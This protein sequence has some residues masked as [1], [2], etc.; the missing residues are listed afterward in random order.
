MNYFKKIIY[1]YRAILFFALFV[2]NAQFSWSQ[3]SN[4]E[5]RC[6]WVVRESMVT[7]QDIDSLMIHAYESGYDIIFAQ[8]RGRGDAY[9]ESELVNK[10]KNIDE[11]F[12]PLDYAIKVG[13]SLGLE[14]HAWVNTY[15][16]WSSKWKPYDKDHLYHTKQEWTEADINGKMD[17]RINLSVPQSP[18]WEGIYLSPLHPEVNSYLSSIFDEIIT[19]Y[20]IDGLHLDYI[21]FQDE[22]Y[23]YNPY[24]REKFKEQYNI[25][26][27]DIAR[28]IISTRFGWEQSFVDS[29]QYSWNKFRQDAVTELVES[30]RININAKDKKIKLSAAVKPNLLEAKSRWYQDW[31]VWLKQDL[32]DFAVPMNYF[33]DIRDFNNS[34]LIMKDNL[35]EKDLD[36]IIM[37]IAT[38]NQD[39]QSSADKILLTRLNGF[40][41]VSV[42][43]YDS[44]KNNLDWFKPV[45]EAFGEQF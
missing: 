1:N 40:K 38:Y 10:Q 30:L 16:L 9:Y 36:K 28:G 4:L 11:Y 5:Q 6:L 41:G 14:V 26:P 20:D 43:S 23:G 22:F 15:I 3:L 37:G 7:S 39:A 27:R 44:H 2:F 42:F 45:I 35:G 8:V 19:R 12:D 31:S 32:L 17:W 18:Q 21:R 34:I 25:D 29:M 13:H 33:K 24:G